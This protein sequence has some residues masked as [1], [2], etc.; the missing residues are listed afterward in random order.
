MQHVVRFIWQLLLEFLN[1]EK[2]ANRE[3]GAVQI[4][5]IAEKVR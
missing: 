2:S 1:R 3:L 5:A 4:L